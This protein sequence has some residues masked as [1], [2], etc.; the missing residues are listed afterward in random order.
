MWGQWHFWRIQ[1][2]YVL[3]QQQQHTQWK[4]CP[5]SKKEKKTNL[6]SPKFPR[7]SNI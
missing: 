3:G 2:R 7:G 5:W 6:F 1:A 4:I